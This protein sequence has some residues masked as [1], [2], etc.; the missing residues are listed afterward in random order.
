[1][2]VVLTEEVKKLGVRGDIREVK[3]G[4][5]R[6]C[7]LP[8]GRAVL[9]GTQAA[10]TILAEMAEKRALKAKRKAEATGPKKVKKSLKRELKKK[11][12]EKKQIKR[13]K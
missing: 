1:M 3:D 7:L 2:K 8:Q 13:T 5:G 11:A 6:N 4:Y 10:K 9:F 12:K